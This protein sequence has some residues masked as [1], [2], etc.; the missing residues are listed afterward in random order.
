M[1]D[2][3][4]AQVKAIQTLIEVLQP[5]DEDQRANVL[6]FVFRSLKIKRSVASSASGGGV[7]A[8]S[9]TSI[10]EAEVPTPGLSTAGD[11]R[12][13]TGEKKP[14]TV[15]QMVAV[16]GYYLA[17]LA[18]DGERR[19]HIVSDDI[20]KY[21]VQAGFPLP[22]GPTTMT[23][24]NAKNAGYLDALEKGKYRLNAVGH[25]LV[26][27]KMPAEAGTP[28]SHRRVVKKRQPSTKTK[29]KR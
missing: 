15:N 23:L 14:S 27:H 18:P 22:T 19:D 1:S 29:K 9:A 25:N 4:E 5:L 12:S 11:I 10:L 13:F 28:S 21:F 17:H 2:N 6:D 3:L 8:N 7:L 24:V 20:K 26:V 16:L